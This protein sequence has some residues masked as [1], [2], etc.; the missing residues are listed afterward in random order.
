[1]TTGEAVELF[2]GA[3]KFGIPSPALLRKWPVLRNEVLAP[4]HLY[5]LVP[6]T[7]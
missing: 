4:I 3:G 7:T 2:K 5:R 1:M 6:L